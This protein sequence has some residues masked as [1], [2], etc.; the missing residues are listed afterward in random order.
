M[1]THRFTAIVPSRFLRTTGIAC[2]LGALLPACVDAEPRDLGFTQTSDE[3]SLQEPDEP[4]ISATSEFVGRWV[5]A[6]QEPLALT[7][8]GVTT[9][10]EFPSGSTRIEVE[11]TLEDEDYLT[12]RIVFG[13]GEP[14]PPPV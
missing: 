3:L 1:K 8:D 7:D 9:P 5:G 2:S 6:A 14:P 10:Y 4:F 12:G 11:L 13:A